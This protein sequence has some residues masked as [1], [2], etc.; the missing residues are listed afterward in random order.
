M[1]MKE[2]QFATPDPGD[3]ARADGAEEGLRDL[4]TR[5]ARSLEW[6]V[7]GD[8]QEQWCHAVLD[9]LPAAIYTTDASGRITYYNQAAAD[10][11]G[12]SP[13]L[14][15]DHWCVTWRLYQTDGTPLPHD[16]CPM[17]IALKENRAVRGQEAIA[18]RPDGTRFPF[19]PYPTPLRDES[20]RLIGAVNMLVNIAER[21][22]AEDALRES[23]ERFR[24]LNETLEAR[25]A[26]RT[27]D[28]AEANARLRAEAA[29]RERAEAALRQAQKMEAVGQLTSGVAHDFNNLLTSILGNLELLEMGL[30]DERLRKLVQA[31]SR[32]AQR[33][34]RLNDQL[35]AFSRKQHLTLKPVD[36][37]ALI[38]GM[39]D[40][41]TRTLGGTVTVTTALAPGLWPA[42]IDPTQIELALLNL[43]INARDAM[44][45][46][47]MVLVETRNL[48]TRRGTEPADLPAGDYIVLAVSDTG[49]GM[50]ELTLARACEPFYT[51]KGPGEGSGL[52]LS[53][54][55]GVAKQ[56]HGSLAIRSAFGEGT[57]VEIYLPRS[58]A[59]VGPR[60]ARGTETAGRSD[61][62]ISVL[63]IDDQ[64]DVRE[65]MVAHLQALGYE[66][67]QAASGQE[68]LDRL[69][70]GDA[71][72]AL[73]ADYAMPEMSGTELARAAQALNQELGVVIVTGYVDTSGVNDQIGD[74][75][76]LKKPY[77]RS[78][79]AAALERVMRGRRAATNIVRLR[80]AGA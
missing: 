77:R 11:A 68:A 22:A 54:V 60:L 73:I 78:E 47:G 16:A 20:G 55:Y 69:R 72:D 32:A 57:T 52:G 66:V 30:H 43:A 27:R 80:G 25:I 76:L 41:L 8:A 18:E 44:P 50:S 31:A 53:Q 70:D 51:T 39:S 74:A 15:V 42:L 65:V 10:L 59:L 49:G 13:K 6:A 24:R 12:R 2:I 17:A 58:S 23:E 35:L 56:S 48:A 38:D 67:S 71:V 4:S 37:N 5:L 46:G 1:A 7:T 45:L 19:I 75:T 79:L 21:K 14:G 36:L 3:I 40:M 61:R 64:Q 26:A 33:G 29:E 34:A 9:A 28:L 63:V 62:R